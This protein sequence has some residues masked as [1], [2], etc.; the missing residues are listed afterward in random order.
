VYAAARELTG[1]GQLGQDTY[2]A[3]Q[4]LLGDTG[5]VE[6]V[7]LCGYYSLVSFLLNAF[8]A[9]LPPG[10]TPNWDHQAGVTNPDS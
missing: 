5:T 3:V 10:A 6:F 7:T 8:A 9:P 4:R 1:T 2:R